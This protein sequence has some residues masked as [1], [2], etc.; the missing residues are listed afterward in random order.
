MNEPVWI[1]VGNI[2]GDKGDT[3]SGLKILDFYSTTAELPSNASHGDAYGVGAE[4]PYNIYIYSPTKGWVNNGALSPD[5]NEQV[6]N[7]AEATT[8][9]NLTSGEKISIA[10]GKIKKA[11]KDLISHIGNKSNPHEVKAEQ[12]GALS[13]TKI[14]DGKDILGITT[15]GWY[16]SRSTINVPTSN[17]A[18]YV[19]VMVYASTY[20][21]VYWRPHDSL[22]EYI[23]VLN[24]GTWLGWSEVFTNNGGSLIGNVEIKKNDSPY[25]TLR[26]NKGF[27]QMLRNANDTFDG[28]VILKDCSNSEK[29][30]SYMALNLKHSAPKENSVFLTY[31]EDE[32]VNYYDIYGEHNKPTGSYSGQYNSQ[33]NQSTDEFTVSI[34]GIGSALLINGMF[35]VT[36][37]GAFVGNNEGVSFTDKIKYR[38]G[39]LNIIGSTANL[40]GTTYTYQVL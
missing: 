24:G 1:K 37:K 15:D 25:F 27:S 26:T 4:A 18:G 23:N 17:D 28:G 13:K 34:G 20:R 33:S 32:N 6:P 16:Y 40:E 19:R 35:L 21:V 31:S 11:I 5:I 30:S 12:V 29:G 38:N 39:T 10:F 36:Y 8:L 14:I 22:K 7:Y 9:E 3:G 2:K